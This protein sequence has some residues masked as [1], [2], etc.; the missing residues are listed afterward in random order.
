MSTPTSSSPPLD[1]TYL[2][3]TLLA[4]DPAVCLVPPRIMRRVI[5]ADRH[6]I[7]LGVHVPHVK[8]YVI[9]RDALLKLAEP[10]ELGVAAGR[11]LPETVILLVKPDPDKLAALSRE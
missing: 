7:G 9:G 5:K 4:I 8:S 2:G 11:T 10:A 1:P 3:Q 6:I